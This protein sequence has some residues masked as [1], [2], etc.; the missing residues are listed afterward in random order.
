MSIIHRICDD[1]SLP[2]SWVNKMVAKA[3]HSYKRYSIPKK[4]G[5]SRTIAQPSRETKHLQYWAIENIISQLPVHNAATAYQQGK[6]IKDNASIHKSNR[7]LAKFDFSNFF[8]S[9][10]EDDFKK[11]LNEHY[12]PALNDNDIKILTRILFIAD[13]HL[14]NHYLS[15]GAPSS[16]AL[17]NSILYQFD[18]MVDEFCNRNT[19][20]YSRYADDLTFS[21]NE[22][23]LLFCLPRFLNKALEE[24][25][26]PSL[27]LNPDKQ[28]FTSKRFNRTVTGIVISNEGTLSLG[29]ERKRLYSSL[30]HKYSHDLLAQNDINRL[31]GY[32]AFARDIEPKF[33]DRLREKYSSDVVDRLI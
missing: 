19:I 8:P 3:P 25:H 5:G 26:Y 27:S 18:C 33:I 24:I 6:S 12:T 15:I 32:L 16:P 29:R 11:H 1:L 17:S 14:K 10:T 30:V 28:V 23:D 22:K 9:I 13:I 31:K 20:S 7:Y 2:P 21:T 4:S